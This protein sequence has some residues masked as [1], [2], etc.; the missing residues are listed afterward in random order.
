MPG[1]KKRNK[2]IGKT[3][4]RSQSVQASSDDQ[5]LEEVIILLDKIIT[6]YKEGQEVVTKVSDG[7]FAILY[8]S[9]AN[10]VGKPNEVLELLRSTRSL[11]L[12][13]GLNTA[14]QRFDGKTYLV[15]TNTIK[16]C[17]SRKVI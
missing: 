10:L 9:N 17:C 8:P 5:L 13:S 16:K 14:T 11:K 4:D 6:L 15:L 2:I 3:V 7:S 12:Q 1:S